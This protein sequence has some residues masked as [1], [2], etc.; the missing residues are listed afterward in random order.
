MKRIILLTVCLAFAACSASSKS[1]TTPDDVDVND[2]K[3]VVGKPLRDGLQGSW[4]STQYAREGESA[5]SMSFLTGPRWWWIAV[6][7]LP[8]LPHPPRL[9]A[10]RSLSILW[11][12]C[13]IHWQRPMRRWGGISSISD[14][15]AARPLTTCL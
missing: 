5:I 6:R 7:L 1:N 10:R 4:T 12:R 2:G 8:V 13:L 3:A 15:L 9:P 11:I 14:L